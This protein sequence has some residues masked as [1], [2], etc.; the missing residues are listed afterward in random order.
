M[1]APSLVRGGAA[2]RHCKGPLTI[3]DKGVKAM[4]Q[5]VK[6]V[7]RLTGL[8][9]DPQSPPTACQ[10]AV[11]GVVSAPLCSLLLL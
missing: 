8:S 2:D 4:A 5:R 11:M 6:C 3:K 1:Q 9:S 7:L 10:A